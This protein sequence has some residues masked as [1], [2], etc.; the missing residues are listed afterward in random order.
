M[1]KEN[2]FF[3]FLL[4]FSCHDECTFS[5]WKHTTS[6]LVATQ[7]DMRHYGGSFQILDKL[8]EKAQKREEISEGRQG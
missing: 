5:I 4:Y 2:N 3:S 6:Q 1:V 8:L 7:I